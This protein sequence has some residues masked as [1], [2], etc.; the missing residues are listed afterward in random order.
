MSNERAP[1][2]GFA[3]LRA[4]TARAKDNSPGLVLD[5][6]SLWPHRDDAEPTADARDQQP[7]TEAAGKTPV[8]WDRYI[9]SRLK[10]FSLR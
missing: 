4:T 3:S 2:H 10:Q 8:M 5:G 1:S 7:S 9:D 6:S